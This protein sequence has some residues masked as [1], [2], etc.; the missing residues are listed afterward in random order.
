MKDWDVFLGGKT[1]CGCGKT[2]LCPI[3]KIV[4]KEGALKE[5]PGA[6]L[7][8][9]YQ[10]IVVI[11]DVNTEIAAGAVLK[12][13]LEEAGISYREHIFEAQELIPDEQAVGE[14]LL[15]VPEESDLILAVGSGTINDLCRYVSCRLSMDYFIVAT[16]PSMD[17]YASNVAPLI[18]HH[19]KTTYEIGCAKMIFGDVTILA[20]APLSMI[21]A[22]V[23]DI[24]GKYV[25]LA[26]WRLS[27][28][29]NEEYH[30]EYIDGLVRE[31]IEAVSVNAIKTMERDKEAVEAVMDA[32]VLSGIA[33][34][35]AKISRPASGSEHHISHYWEMMALQ[36]GEP[37]AFHGTKVGIATVLM[38]KMY[39]H[40]P[41]YIEILKQD[42]K[43][44]ESVATDGFYDLQQWKHRIRKKY[45]SSAKGVLE[46]EEKVQ[47]NNPREIAKRLEK[48]K[49]YSSQIGEMVSQLP[50]AEEIR[51]LLEHMG[52]PS[53][54]WQI[55]ITKERLEDSILYAKELRNRY[56]LLQM[57]YDLHL[58]EQE[59]ARFLA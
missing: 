37:D 56:G 42:H 24:L 51:S 45:G 53:A 34:S 36:N 17:G 19:L 22:G 44:T 26:D 2:H 11:S 14:L 52:A 54:P 55:D 48:V 25:G 27:H 3:E 13:F 15:A 38:L 30:C 50:Q 29:V 46:L 31:S 9:A 20:Q 57:Y 32:L 5:V 12:K 40:L 1:D 16:A 23:G 21:Q 7:E 49:E 4:I 8:G 39:H 33:M 28:M 6:V 47:K 43:D 18:V 59:A 41:K 35:Y 58:L 10:N